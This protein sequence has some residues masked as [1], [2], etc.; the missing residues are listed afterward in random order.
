MIFIPQKRNASIYRITARASFFRC[1]ARS[2]CFGNYKNAPSKLEIG[3]LLT[4]R[5]IWLHNEYCIT[6][7]NFAECGTVEDSKLFG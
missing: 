3:S 2:I 1:K 5:A 7:L 6:Y 4:A